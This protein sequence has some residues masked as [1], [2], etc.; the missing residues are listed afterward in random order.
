MSGA[1]NIWLEVGLGVGLFT[2]II[3]LLVLVI[4]FARSKLVA[5]GVV[6]VIVNE[7]RELA[8][9]PG[10][11]LMNGLADANLFVASACGGGGT[12]GQCKVRVPRGGGAVL[13]TEASLL[14]KREVSQH[15]RLSCQVSVK[16]DMAVEVPDE[17]FGVRK[18]TCRVI[19]RSQS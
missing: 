12:C 17:V 15:Y 10:V 13:P 18:F 14:S 6:K 3:L 8:M 16:Q 4:L 2:G 19:E 11:K 1:G 7:E 9:A 5:S